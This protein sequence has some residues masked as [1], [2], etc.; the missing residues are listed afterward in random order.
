MQKKKNYIAWALHFLY[1]G[2]SRSHVPCSV[3]HSFQTYLEERGSGLAEPMYMVTMSNIVEDC[4]W[5]IPIGHW[6][7]LTPSSRRWQLRSGSNEI[8]SRVLYIKGPRVLCHSHCSKCTILV[9][10]TLYYSSVRRPS[11]LLLGDIIRNQVALAPSVSSSPTPKYYSFVTYIALY[12]VHSLTLLLSHHSA[13]FH[14]AKE[15][16]GFKKWT[17]SNKGWHVKLIDLREIKYNRFY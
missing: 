10:C 17:I 9:K 11:H 12:A 15:S 6:L 2:I 1:L 14:P 8:R 13:Q 16:G 7:V 5:S 3:K 4:H